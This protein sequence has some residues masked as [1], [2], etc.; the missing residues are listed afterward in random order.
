MAL[1]ARW[2]AF[3]ASAAALAWAWAVFTTS[4]SW[5]A[6]CLATRSYSAC[7]VD[8]TGNRAGVPV[9]GLL[10]RRANCGSAMGW[11]EAA[12]ASRR[13]MENT[14]TLASLLICRI[15]A[16]LRP[17]VLCACLGSWAEASPTWTM[18]RRAPSVQRVS[19]SAV[20]MPA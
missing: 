11:S 10:A 1:A 18:K 17:V 9:P 14:D 6:I 7:A 19:S 16:A 2:A 8:S 3:A 12:R 13:W 20:F 15:S 5:P 4:V